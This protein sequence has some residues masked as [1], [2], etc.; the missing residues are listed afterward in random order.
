MSKLSFNIV[1]IPEGESRHDKILEPEDLDLTPYEFTGGVISI[2]FNRQRRFIEVNYDLEGGVQL[3]CDRSLET[4]DHPIDTSYNVIFKTDVEKET[5]DE[6]GAVR[7]FNFSGNTFSIEKEV[8]DSV[9][10]RIPIKK[11][12]PKFKDEEGIVKE[13]EEKSF[14]EPPEE[15]EDPIDPRWEKLKKIKAED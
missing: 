11:I 5:E 9:L 6:N 1:E 3:T 14:N 15:E 7:K 10:L 8:R 2:R 4:F 13:F 12:H